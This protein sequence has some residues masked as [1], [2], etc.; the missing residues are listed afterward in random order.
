MYRVGEGERKG[1]SFIVKELTHRK[2]EKRHDSHVK[3]RLRD[4]EIVA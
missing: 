4:R 1:K 2:A 3:D